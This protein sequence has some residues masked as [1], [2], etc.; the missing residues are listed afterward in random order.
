MLD[1]DPAL[2]V[3]VVS[4]DAAVIMPGQLFASGTVTGTVSTVHHDL[5]GSTL[6]TEVYL[7]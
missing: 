5:E 7:A 2:G 3:V 6:R 4:D 1:Y